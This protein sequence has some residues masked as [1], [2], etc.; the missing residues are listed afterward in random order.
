MVRCNIYGKL[1]ECRGGY[2]DTFVGGSMEEDSY[3]SLYGYF[4][5]AAVIALIYAFFML[6]SVLSMSSGGGKA[7]SIS[8]AIHDSVHTFLKLQFK[9]LLSV[10]LGVILIFLLVGRSISF[11]F[12]LMFLLGSAMS[13]FVGY[14]SILVAVRA[15]IRTLYAAQAYGLK[16]SFET[17]FN[18]GVFSGLLV[19]GIICLSVPLLFF[20]YSS[21][22][23]TVN[24]MLYS[25]YPLLCLCLGA[26]SNH[27][28]V[29]LQGGIL[30]KSADVGADSITK[31]E[32]G[33]P[34]DDSRNPATIL[35]NVCENISSC[36]DTVTDFFSSYLIC[37]VVGVC[38]ARLQ[39]SDLYSSF[40]FYSIM[41]SSIAATIVVTFCVKMF[42]GRSIMRSFRMAVILTA[43]LTAA[44]MF[45]FNGFSLESRML[46]CSVVGLLV[47]VS[48]LLSVERFTGTS[49]AC[50]SVAKAA[51]TGAATAVIRTIAVS[52]LKVVFPI[53]MIAVGGLVAYMIAGGV[54]F[55]VAAMAVLSLSGI[56]ISFGV[57]AAVS[58]NAGALAEMSACDS[59]VRE[60]IDSLDESGSVGVKMVSMYRVICTGFTVLVVLLSIE[61]LRYMGMAATEFEGHMSMLLS[62]AGL[63][64][65]A[66]VVCYFSAK[67]I[68]AL[69]SVA[70]VIII[71]T[72][73][74]FRE[75]PGLPQGE[76][77]PNYTRLTR[78]ATHAVMKSVALPL[79]FSIL[80]PWVIFFIYNYWLGIPGSGAQEWVDHAA[81]GSFE[82][83]SWMHF[84]GGE[85]LLLWITV[86]AT[87]VGVVIQLLMSTIHALSD[88]AKKYTESTLGAGKGTDS[89][90]ATVVADTVGDGVLSVVPVLNVFLKLSVVILLF[91]YYPHS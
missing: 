18:S 71:E 21:S 4:F 77:L 82:V 88:S 59:G 53:V 68:R 50:V 69:E 78:L 19:L 16:S 9:Y 48:L 2:I 46:W 54:G 7:A 89:N 79:L 58:D 64:I 29:G 38:F 51:E 15:N 22:V 49:H 83:G 67:L 5:I 31:V 17:A 87:V 76:A 41:L 44:G 85:Q 33:I 74:Q 61:F 55:C 80:A 60:I 34:E 66:A 52:L 75:I 24:I 72:R 20:K 3:F 12:I 11:F 35:D 73:R 47:A 36:L 63:F 90:K 65:G 1:Q 62:W 39:S 86:G 43:I 42:D 25:F 37:L 28:F 45:C 81:F 27:L 56:V 8:R 23:H 10:N 26:L 13:F 14:L 6:G 70:Y 40:P 32:A 91:F 57:F 84:N 30:T